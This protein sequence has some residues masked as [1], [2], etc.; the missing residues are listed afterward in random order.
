MED[1]ISIAGGTA[2]TVTGV[3]EEQNIFPYFG[4]SD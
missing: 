4:L 1:A 2:E 3:L